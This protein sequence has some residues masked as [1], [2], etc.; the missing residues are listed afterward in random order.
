MQNNEQKARYARAFLGDISRINRDKQMQ[1]CTETINGLEGVAEL[2]AFYEASEFDLFVK[3]LRRDEI[4][5]VARLIGVAERKPKERPG[6]AFY[7]RLIRLLQSRAAYILDA[8]TG[9]TSLDGERWR[10]LYLRTGR[11]ITRGREL[12]S[13][14]AADMATTRHEN[15]EPGLQEYW[16]SMKGTEEYNRLASHWRDPIYKSSKEARSASPNEEL[17][18]ASDSMWRRIFGGRTARSKKT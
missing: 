7:D 8:H 17:R 10:Q 14:K 1:I 3:Q 5:V 18:T 15:K 13:E 9:I 12:S 2:T 16:E 6:I 11:T 4:A